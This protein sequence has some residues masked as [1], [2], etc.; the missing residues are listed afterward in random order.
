MRPSLNEMLEGLISS[1][2]MSSVSPAFDTGNRF[3]NAWRPGWKTWA[4][5]SASKR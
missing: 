2:S 5:R 1:P 3:R 4:S